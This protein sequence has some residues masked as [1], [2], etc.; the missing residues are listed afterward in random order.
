MAVTFLTVDRDTPD[1]FPASVQEYLPQDHLA[2]FVVEIVDQL[3]L[4]HLVSA[5]AGS[6]SRP[7]H[8]A[9]LVALLF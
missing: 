2:W 8:S 7:Y 9:M 4:S 3:D 1:L 6:G 5:Y